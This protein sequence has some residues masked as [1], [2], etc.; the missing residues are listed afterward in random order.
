MLNRVI[1]AL[2][3]EI[4]ALEKSALKG[5]PDT[6]LEFHFGIRCGEWRGLQKALNVIQQISDEIEAAHEIRQ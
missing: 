5:P 2:E 3:A 6:N 1:S 4:S